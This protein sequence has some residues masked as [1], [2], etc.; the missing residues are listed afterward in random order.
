[1]P[2]PLFLTNARLIDPENGTDKL[3]SIII[4]NGKI[5][6]ITYGVAPEGAL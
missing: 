5:A 3:G 1:M 6:D 2:A 4:K